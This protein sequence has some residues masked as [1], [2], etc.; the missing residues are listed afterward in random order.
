MKN[1]RSSLPCISMNFCKHKF[2]K[3]QVLPCEYRLGFL[4]KKYLMENLIFCAVKG[5]L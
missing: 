4:Q 1:V 3:A 5:S 2:T